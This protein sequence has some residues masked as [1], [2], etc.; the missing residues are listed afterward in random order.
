MFYSKEEFKE[1]FSMRLEQQEQPVT[2][3]T[4]YSILAGMVR[5][6][7]KRD[8]DETNHFYQKEQR[9]QL[10][11]FSIEF[12][13][14]RMLGQNLMNLTIYELVNEGLGEL[15]YDLAELEEQEPEPGL[16]NGGLGRLA[17]CFMDSLASLQMPGHGCG[18]RYR[19]GLFSQVLKD[20][21]QTEHPTDW[22]N[23]SAGWDI[24][25]EDLATYIP[26]FGE[27]QPEHGQRFKASLT[28]AE[29]VKAVPYD[30]PIVG[31][32]GKTVN[33]LRLW[34]AELPE[35]HLLPK[36]DVETYKQHVVAISDRL[37]PDDSTEE[38]KILRLKQQ[39][40]LCSASLQTILKNRDFP[41]SALP[42]HVAIQINDTHPALAIPELMRLLL[43]GEGLSWE[44]AWGITTHTI[45][46]TNHT[47]LEEAME[48]WDSSMLEQLLPRIYMI[49]Q[50]I[51]RR[52]KEKCH[53]ENLD[54]EAKKKLSII[55]DG[56]VKMATLAVVGSYKVNGVAK[57]H[58][59]ILKMREMKE[60]NEH[61]PH[62]F[63][64]KTNGITH[65]R[66]LMKAN[67]ELSSLITS[68]I[69]NEWT[70]DPVKLHQLN[71]FVQDPV[72][73]G[74]FKSVKQQK[75]NQLTEYLEKN[76]T[77]KIDPES[78]FDMHIKRFHG[79]KRQL[80]NIFHIQM[81][82]NRIKEDSAYRP[83]PRTFFFGGK[84]AKSYRF[85]KQVIKLINTVAEKINNDPVASKHLHIVFVEDYN[86]SRA[87]KM[88][89]A[90]DI[91]EQISTA[92][93]E[94]SG[95][96]NMKFMM[97][98]AITLGTFDGANIEIVEQ[99]G[100]DN[101]FIFGVTAQ[102]VMQFEEEKTYHAREI[103]EKDREIGQLISELLSGKL[104][105]GLENI[106]FIRSQIID[107]NDPYFVL[108]DLQHYARTHNRVL[109]VYED[110]LAWQ[111][112]S[113]VN[114]AQSGIFSSDRTIQQYSDEVWD[115]EKIY[116]R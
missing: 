93:K 52:F 90:A 78:I 39:Y 91:S 84:A 11:Y 9:K 86:V 35:Q 47:I 4:A 41:V 104:S 42:K 73:L 67:P 107:E 109:A 61:F 43:D 76:Q 13:I 82:Y 50:E 71:E 70:K 56:I 7:V 98:G 10:Y 111:E 54:S 92:S 1:N 45:S 44:E 103:I 113:A 79:Y 21:F 57:L 26:F 27:V 53:Q 96:G 116:S 34:Q 106:D 25:R 99:I 95:T 20:G 17:A 114:I 81:L 58:T 72:F 80:M 59:E 28:N 60:L 110:T 12:L 83:Y 16:G 49:I 115:L 89:P 85:A 75:K 64:N 40:F 8:W 15:G 5:E 88:F 22:I 65:R 55:E 112:M 2:L 31:A 3:Q 19:G 6:F 36:A 74:D 87:E 108:K 100:D 97:N 69:G 30:M 101:A 68:V 32:Y 51:D 23:D 63:H 94:A 77:I 29:W 105:K 24:R 48:K 102:Q 62:K 14:G 37:Y 46:Y 33:T 38:G 18:I 66:W